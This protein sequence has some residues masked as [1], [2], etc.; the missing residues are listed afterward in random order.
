MA[1]II[2]EK[3][4]HSAGS[5]LCRQLLS[6][7]NYYTAVSIIEA[8]GK[9]DYEVGLSTIEEWL[10]THTKD[11]VQSKMFTVF[12]HAHN[13]IVRLD[14]T[15]EGSHRMMFA[16]RYERYITEDVPL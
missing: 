11:I 7:D 2:G 16:Q 12:R 10:S 5:A 4:L 15:P 14:H 6:E 13:S 3:Q 8:I 9:L 1:D